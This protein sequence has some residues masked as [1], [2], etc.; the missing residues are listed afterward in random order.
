[1]K[2]TLYGILLLFITN[3]LY[4]QETPRIDS[5]ISEGLFAE[6]LNE[7]SSSATHQADARMLFMLNCKKS[8]TLIRLGRYEEAETLLAK[9][10]VELPEGSRCTLL[11]ILRTTEGLLNMNRGRNDLALAALQSAVG[12]WSEC[13]QMHSLGAAHSQALLGNLYLATGKYTQAEE[14]L[15]IAQITRQTLLPPNHE[16]IAASWNDLGLV[17]TYSDPD[18]ALDHYEKALS[19]Y[20]KK[21]GQN[22]PR[23]AIASTN[24]GFLYNR[25]ELY[26]DAINYFESA[27]RIWDGVYNSPHPS[28]AFVLFNLGQTQEQ[29]K[30]HKAAKEYYEK[31]AAIYEAS[32]GSRHPDLARAYNALGN[33]EKASGNFAPAL[34]LYQKALEVNHPDFTS[35]DF[36]ATP[37]IT[38]FYDGNVLLHTLLNKAQVLEDSYVKKT[39]L[40]RELA[41]SVNTLI[42]CDSLIDILRKQI[43]NESDKITLGAMANEVYASGVRICMEAAKAAWNKDRYFSLAFFFAEKSK[44]AVLLNAI[45][46]A[47]ARTF[48]GIP[49]A[50]LEEEKQLKAAITLTARKLAQ[51]PSP[52]EEVY[53]RQTYY[54]LNRSYETLAQKLEKEYPSY[55]NLKYN[56]TSPAIEKIQGALDESTMLIS[57]FN[58]DE[59]RRFYVFTISAKTFTAEERTVPP[60]LDRYITGLRNS[61]YYSTAE[62]YEEA[63]GFLSKA[64]LPSHIPK[65]VK[66]L[67]VLPTGR[68]GTIPFETLLTRKIAK[69]GDYSSYPYLVSR[70]NVRYEFSAGLILQKQKEK[71]V[72]GSSILV[73]APVRFAESGSLPDLP[74]TER[75]A[76]HLAS[77]FAGQN[78]R[79]RILLGNDA[80]ETTIKELRL[81]DYSY[82]HFATHG[83]VDEQKPEL[84]RIF[85]AAHEGSE[86]GSLFAGEI[87]NLELNA[88]LVTLSACQTGLG[89]ISKGEGVIGL[90]RALVYAGAERCLVSY[91]NV[92]DQ[93]TADLMA[94][95]YRG[96]AI[97]NKSP[98]EALQHAKLGMLQSSS[99]AAPF[100]WAPFILI[101]F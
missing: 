89:K 18:K 6:A 52:Q 60:P 98:A 13:G 1:M 91:W 44:S 65:R 69:D 42:S 100:Y 93:S 70:Y 43:Q 62:T 59:N 66:S 46:E 28:K 45:A 35:S 24:L 14:Q 34:R 77:L 49:P 3:A 58:D 80:D 37:D 73:C 84:S 86:D 81:K 10:A 47:N 9:T 20:E 32:Y 56:T 15:L 57:Y 64:L 75:E 101:G 19:L 92:A 88:R 39:L 68:L 96:V 74:G 25:L 99:Y 54:E 63:A 7:I 29:L 8:E 97:E 12:H 53:L 33:L 87:Y 31:A 82:I 30:D 95:F 17:Y 11:P 94:S 78:L 67:I 61:L 4:A 41:L 5:L 2:T 79:S 90:S 40:F 48:S 71:A 72:D 26:G 27:L 22:H 21:H 85:L 38:R 36:S 51:K 16:L 76:T 55:F 83:I 23:I 50:L